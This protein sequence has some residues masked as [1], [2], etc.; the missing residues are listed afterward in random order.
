MRSE[1]RLYQ[2][3]AHGKSPW[4]LGE[5]IVL[6]VWPFVWGCLCGWTPKPFNRW[7]IVVLQWFGM[8][9]GERVFVHSR[10][11]IQKPWNV[12]MESGSC[13]GDRANLYSLDVITIG[14]ESIVAQEAY[15]CTGSHKREI[16]GW[17]LVTAPIHIGER[18]FVGARA[19]VLPG[20]RIGN[21]ATV[22]ACSVVTR[23]VPDGVTV[24]GNPARALPGPNPE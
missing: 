15:L 8:K 5:R 3:S 18:A 7:R 6:F 12:T 21:H 4:G 14:R 23:D 20:V 22:G 24:V 17:P 13:L 9:M 10:A 16:A 19:F 11:R 1:Q 2:H